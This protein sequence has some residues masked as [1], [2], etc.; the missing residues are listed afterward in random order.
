VTLEVT[1]EL[2]MQ[3]RIAL[4]VSAITLEA[5]ASTTDDQGRRKVELHWAGAAGARVLVVRNGAVLGTT[6]NS[7]AATHTVSASET[8]KPANY[9]VCDLAGDSCS[10]PVIVAPLCAS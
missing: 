9:R 6:N 10:P 8:G 4:P 2:G 1:N 7:G 3:S 5:I